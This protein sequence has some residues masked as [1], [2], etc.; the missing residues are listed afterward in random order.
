MACTGSSAQNTITNIGDT[1]QV[2]VNVTDCD[3]VAVNVESY[4]LTYKIARGAG[5]A[6]LITKTETD[7]ITVDVGEVT[8]L[9][10]AA[11]TAAMANNN[12]HHELVID[13]GTTFQT[14]MIGLHLFTHSSVS[15]C[16]ALSATMNTVMF[17][18]TPYMLDF[19][20]AQNSAYISMF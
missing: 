12:Y 13:D 7:G 19:S 3:G 9:L 2:V 14:V 15:C 10:D 11:D 6:A 16:D 20:S 5:V 17:G 18:A 1:R 8:I 4:D